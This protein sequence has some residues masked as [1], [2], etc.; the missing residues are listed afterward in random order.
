MPHC[1]P[2]CTRTVEGANG[3]ARAW[4]TIG[5]VHNRRSSTF[6]KV[7]Y[8]GGFARTIRSNAGEELEIARDIVI[9][10]TGYQAPELA[11]A[12][13]MLQSAADALEPALAAHAGALRA[14]KDAWASVQAAKCNFC[15]RYY[16][17]Y[18]QL[19]QILGDPGLASTYFPRARRAA[20]PEEVPES[21]PQSILSPAPE[22]GAVAAPAVGS[23]AV[24]PR[25]I[26]RAEPET[27]RAPAADPEEVTVAAG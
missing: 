17:L 1:P 3:R 4:C 18:C 24:V 2:R 14:E 12:I 19:V 15:K 11:P 23:L 13:E 20:R 22:A 16:G 26:S 27:A 25:P 21:A 9:K 8:P 10:L 7:I 5:W 6:Y